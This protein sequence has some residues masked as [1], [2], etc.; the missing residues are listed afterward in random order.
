M[1]IF[2]K[3]QKE[4]YK[5]I[6]AA[7]L[8]ICILFDAISPTAALALTG[9]PSQ[10]EVQSFEPVG[11]SNMVD[12]FSGDFNYNIPL[13]DVGGY[14]INIAYHSGIGMDQEASWTGLGWN[15]NPGVINRNMRGIPDDFDGDLI[16]K[17]FNMK[18]NKTV[19]GSVGAGIELAGA[20]KLKVGIAYS[21]GIR[22]NNYTGFG[23]EKSLNLSISASLGS[24]GGLSGGLGITS[25]SDDGLTLQPSVSFSAKTGKS[26][27][28]A[29]AGL[30]LSVGTAYNSRGGLKSLTVSANVSVSANRTSDKVK[31]NAG[32][33]ISGGASHSQGGSASFD[34]GQPTYSPMVQMSMKN[35]SVTGNFKIGFEAYTLHPNFTVGGYYSCQEL[36]VKSQS[37]PAFGYMFAHEGTKYDN[38]IMDFNREKDGNFN[39]STPALPLANFTYD[40]FTVAGQGVGGSYRTFR[41]DVGHVFDANNYSTSDGYAI[42]AEVGIGNLVHVGVD[43]SVNNTDT[44]SNKWSDDNQAASSLTHKE[45]GNNGL[46]EPF[47]FKEANEKSVDSDPNYI[48]N[49]GGFEPQR[50][51]LKQQSK[52]NTIATSNFV[53]RYGT[54]KAIGNNQRATREKR[55]QVFSYLTRGEVAQFGIDNYANLYTP[56]NPYSINHHIAEIT[57]LGMDG[58]RY[59]YGIAAYNTF[60]KEVSFAVNGSG[61]PATGLVSYSPGSDNSTSNSSGQ[62]NFYSSTTTP[63][64]AHSY[65]LTSVLSAD[66]VDSDGQRG[67]TDGDLGNYTKFKYKK[68]SN[69]NWR[70][71]I[72]KNKATANPGLMTDNEDDKANY[73]FGTKDLSFLDTVITKNYI[74]IFYKS[75]RQDALGAIDENGG[76]N[77]AVRNLKL[78]SI[79]LFVKRDYYSNVNAQSIKTVHF[80][81]DYSLCPQVENRVGGA[82]SSLG[83]L[84]LK[85]I[86]F[87]YQG[88]T[89]GRFSSY[90]FDYG[91]LNPS[92]NIKGYDRWGNY[93]PVTTTPQGSSTPINTT[94]YPYVDQDKTITDQYASAWTLDKITLPSG[95]TINITYESDDYAYVQN[96]QANRMFMLK[97]VGAINGTAL[98]S[99]NNEVLIFEGVKGYNNPGDYGSPGQL[100]YFRCLM[101]FFSSHQEYVSGYARISSIQV[102]PGTGSV[103][104][105][106]SVTLVPESDLNM[107]GYN[108]ITKAGI[109]YVRLNRPRWAFGNNTTGDQALGKQLLESWI[110]SS[111][112][113]NMIDAAKGPNKAV[114]DYGNANSLVIGKSWIRMLEPTKHKLGGGCRIKQI[115]LSD[116]WNLMTSGLQTFSYG[117][118]YSYTNPDGS[119]SGV[120][121]YEPQLGGDENP[122]KQPVFFTESKLLAPDDEHYMEEPFGE[123]FFPS[124][125]VG[126]SR[127]EVKNISRKNVKKH[128]TGKVVH[129]FY[130]AKD[131][132]TIVERTGVDPRREKTDP[133]SLKSIFKVDTKDYFTAS[134]GFYIELNDMHGKPK[135]QNVY[136]EFQTLPISSVEY[137]YKSTPYANNSARL[138]NSVSVIKKDGGVASANIG[139]FFDAVGDMRE[140]YNQTNSTTIATNVDVFLAGIY[141]IVVPMIWPS[142]SKESI[143]F[144][145]ATYTK[146]VQRF[147][148][149]EETVAKDLGSVVSTKN[150]AYDSET[151]EVLLTQTTTDF[152]DAIYSFTY[153]AHWYY[154]GMGQA[155]KNISYKTNLSFN[156]SGI[157]SVANPQLYFAEG[158]EIALS[159]T[160][161]LIGW[162]TGISGSSISVQTISGAPVAAGSYDIKI[163]RSGR[164]NMQNVPIASMTSLT[165]PL[166]YLTSN[167]FENVLQAEAKEFGNKWRTYCDCFDGGVNSIMTSTNPYVNGTKG[168]W[169]LLKSYLHLT[170]R[171]QSNYNKN[172]NIRK[173]GVFTSYTPFY[174]LSSGTWNK[175]DKNWTY[176]SEVT[177]FNP[178]GQEIENKDALGRYSAA[179]FGYNQSLATAV[180]ANS[181]YSQVGYDN[182]EDYG[183]SKC[184]DN[185]F[186]FTNGIT[187]LNSE[188]HT[189]KHSILV[190]SNTP[191]TLDRQLQQCDKAE[192]KINFTYTATNGNV[193]IINATAPYNITWNIMNGSPNVTLT[194]SGVII[195]N[196][197]GVT[198]PWTVE[199]T[200][201]DSKN[202]SIT[203][204]FTKP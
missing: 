142:F 118:E 78:D 52:F 164:R 188:A 150:L 191:V 120:A 82:S 128:A 147:G 160:T 33:K 167:T 76:A 28:K 59:V 169:R 195:A 132:P 92:Y 162:V 179:T 136:Q 143:Q 97:G 67:P 95:G 73:L 64:F 115:A 105:K 157:A 158:D 32:D 155:Y 35:L 165:N 70:I 37:N 100:M 141:P 8:A 99:S 36:L 137:K 121:S 12:M 104:P 38:A 63:P 119:S 91:T 202:C 198:L 55:N 89:K 2:N 112:I 62:D 96:R 163:V 126:Y 71:P 170:D 185:H 58:S 183:F 1:R 127:V 60:Q 80:V 65:L 189:G 107:S 11:T 18:P 40:M 199:V 29:T 110:N 51:D 39:E 192:C 181:K 75:D 173:D 14:P 113:K 106:V 154:D 129:E 98:S 54:K 201:T 153:P 26:D 53:N 123:T 20:E 124:A 86:Y 114:Y 88:S 23:V 68:V 83:K 151:G 43:F 182:F 194:S 161:S 187:Y 79:K 77:T 196:P 72:E 140:Q 27:S 130:T 56:S 15:I 176:T 122:W 203:K 74:A 101:N 4:R 90:K 111:F 41:S 44:R 47:Y 49:I 131:F 156:A 3:K 94:D 144:R 178:I 197:T 21:I 184:A 42:G 85:E 93:K 19:G 46:Y 146:V 108:P 81:Y 177:E 61:D 109:Q 50:F 135:S 180:A 22:Y 69:Y 84:T 171:T 102:T 204:T 139:V 116:E 159:G 148:I 149:L 34:F 5:R 13:M 10:P 166:N 172:T 134:Q 87:T 186:K 24:N 200:A 117:Q 190:S 9:G 103:P 193:S 45:N 17:D 168:N 30:G 6:L 66:Y 175:D 145:S 48:N 57:N 31:D 7:Y 25:S 16:K 138:E 133:F 152:N 125:S 174:K